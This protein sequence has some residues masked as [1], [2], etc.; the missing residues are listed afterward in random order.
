M[1]RTR[2][3]TAPDRDAIDLTADATLDVP[4]LLAA[5]AVLN[6]TLELAALQGRVQVMIR[7]AALLVSF[8]VASHLLQSTVGPLPQLW[9]IPPA[10]II[11]LAS[12]RSFARHFARLIVSL[13]TT[14][15]SVKF[16]GGLCGTVT[17]GTAR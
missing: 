7:L 17:Q 5:G 9:A 12:A 13:E 15:T 14:A 11:A 4:G 2:I 6:R 8:S 16:M 10:A 1:A 3:S